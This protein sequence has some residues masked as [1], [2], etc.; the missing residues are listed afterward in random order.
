VRYPMASR[1]VGDA[2]N[3]RSESRAFAKREFPTL[4]STHAGHRGAFDSHAAIGIGAG[5]KLAVQG[6]PGAKKWL[7]LPSRASKI[8]LDERVP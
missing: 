6:G 2:P 1:I 4:L 7:T 3:A 5:E 8:K